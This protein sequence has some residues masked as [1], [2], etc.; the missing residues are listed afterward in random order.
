MTVTIDC[1]EVKEEPPTD[2][3]EAALTL[4]IRVTGQPESI[5]ELYEEMSEDPIGAD[6]I[7]RL[8]SALG[9]MSSGLSNVVVTVYPLLPDDKVAAQAEA[10]FIPIGQRANIPMRWIQHRI[11]IPSEARV[12]EG[13]VDVVVTQPG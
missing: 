10:R 3:S 12:I 1:F 5:S 7:A 11:G 9:G 8:A 4:A 6:S 13:S 2:E